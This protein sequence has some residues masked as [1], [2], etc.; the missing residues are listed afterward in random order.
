MEKWTDLQGHTFKGEPAEVIGPLALFRL[1]DRSG[2]KVLLSQLS[3]QDCVR[4]DEQ[5]RALPVPAADWAQS[6][7]NIGSEIYGCARRVQEGRLID[8]ELKGI[9]EPRFYVLCFA[10]NGE[11][12][13]WDMLGKIG[14]PFQEMQKSHP[15]L[16]EGFMFG[17]KH[18][19]LDHTRMAT[20]M[21]VPFLV[22]SFEDQPKMSAILKIVPSANYGVVVCNC[23]GVPL[24]FTKGDTEE[25]AK[26]IMADLHGLLDLLSPNNPRTWVDQLHYWKAVQPVRHAANKSDPMLVGDPLNAEKLLQL[27]VKRFDATLFVSAEGAVTAVSMAAGGEVPEDMVTPITAALQQAQLVPAVDHGKFVAGKFHYRFAPE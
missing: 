20:Q 23:N 18:V 9:P 6:A 7:T 22:S 4:F 3:P 27:S 21:K 10:N 16:V 5:V 15:K 14:W 2:K 11:S 8:A 25:S 24:F 13:S 1:P 17:V 19:G 26:A 12:K